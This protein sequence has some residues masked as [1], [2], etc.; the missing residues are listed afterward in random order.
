MFK[1]LVM[2]TRFLNQMPGQKEYSVSR[3]G[4]HIQGMGSRESRP[5]LLVDVQTLKVPPTIISDLLLGFNCFI[6]P[7]C[8]LIC[9]RCNGHKGLVTYYGEGGGTKRE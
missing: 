2:R 9:N 4:V 3:V 5:S 6:L 1:F 8:P 7:E